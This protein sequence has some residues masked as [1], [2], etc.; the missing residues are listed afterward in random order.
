MLLL[1]WTSLLCSITL[2]TAISQQ[3]GFG[4]T[5]VDAEIKRYVNA[6]IASIAII[7]DTDTPTADKLKEIIETLYNPNIM[8]TPDELANLRGQATQAVMYFKNYIDN[9][10]FGASAI[11]ARFEGQ[12]EGNSQKIYEASQ[13]ISN[14][15]AAIS[16]SLQNT[17]N[18]IQ[19]TTTQDEF[20]TALN[21][22]N[23]H[24]SMATVESFINSSKADLYSIQLN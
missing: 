16:S 19:A 10:N 1:V 17:I 18:A 24:Q 20:K 15:T 21:P 6:L 14:Y 4:E 13:K 2:S 23:L 7:E 5:S 8:L 22:R 9:T 11:S 3:P 12:N